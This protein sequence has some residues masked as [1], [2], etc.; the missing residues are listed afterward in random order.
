MQIFLEPDTD[1]ILQVL[2]VLSI[3]IRLDPEHFLDPDPELF[4]SDPDPDKNKNRKESKF[5]FFFALIVQNIQ[6]N[7]DVLSKRYQLILLFD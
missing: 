5:Y 3:R 6:W 2:A 1:L 4:V 7:V